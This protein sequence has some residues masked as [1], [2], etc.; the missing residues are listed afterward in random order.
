MTG[1]KTGQKIGKRQDRRQDIRHDR[2]QVRGHQPYTSYGGRVLTG[3]SPLSPGL[4]CNVWG[5]GH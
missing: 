4:F 1:K 3:G 5:G 2:R